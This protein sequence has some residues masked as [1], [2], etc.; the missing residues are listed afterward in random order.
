M[1]HGICRG[2]EGHEA[3]ETLP[4]VPNHL[5]DFGGCTRDAVRLA[6]T[7]SLTYYP[8]WT[9]SRLVEVR[10]VCLSH[11]KDLPNPPDGYATTV[12]RWNAR[13]AAGLACRDCCTTMDGWME[14][15][16][17]GITDER[18]NHIE[19]HPYSPLPPRA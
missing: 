19:W 8:N 18:G 3:G 7:T 12:Y 16:L 13:A 15:M 14:Y 6:V 1:D 10:P 4:L 2:H 17:N 11:V 9:M 5:C